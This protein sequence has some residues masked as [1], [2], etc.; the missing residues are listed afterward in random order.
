[1][2]NKIYNILLNERITDILLST[3]VRN[4]ES[5]I[6][7]KREISLDVVRIV[8]NP[9]CIFS[10]SETKERYLNKRTKL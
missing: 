5:N 8:R 9:L 1:M 7:K 10:Y 6:A 2:T 4:I 3:K